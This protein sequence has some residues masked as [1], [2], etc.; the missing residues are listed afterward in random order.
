MKVKHKLG[1]NKSVTYI[2]QR[3]CKHNKERKKEKLRKD[4]CSKHGEIQETNQAKG[5]WPRPNGSSDKRVKI[6]L[7]SM[8]WKN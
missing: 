3:C 4:S 5:V 6:N 2:C 8:R 7:L 1:H